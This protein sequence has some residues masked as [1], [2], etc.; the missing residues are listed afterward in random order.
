MNIMGVT[1][2][3]L[4]GFKA[5]STGGKSCFIINLDKKLCLE[6]HMPWSGGIKPTTILLDRLSIKLPSTLYL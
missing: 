6:H 1:N 2:C 4:I 3:L 5:H